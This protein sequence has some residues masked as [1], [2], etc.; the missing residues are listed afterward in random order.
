MP[1]RVRRFAAVVVVVEPV[2][3]A[4]SIESAYIDIDITTVP[5]HIAARYI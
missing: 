3:P 4:G 5:T 1:T 2:P